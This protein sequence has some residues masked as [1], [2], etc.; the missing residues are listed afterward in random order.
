MVSI[1]LPQAATELISTAFYVWTVTFAYYNESTVV[2][3]ALAAGL[4]ATAISYATNGAAFNPIITYARLLARKVRAT[5][6]AVDVVAQFMG[7]FLASLVLMAG[8]GSGKLGSIAVLPGTRTT[9]ALVS[10]IMASFCMTYLVIKTPEPE[11]VPIVSG[12]ALSGLHMVLL[13]ISGASL[14]P[15]RALAPAIVSGTWG[16]GMWA[17]VVGP[18]VGAAVA[19][20]AERMTVMYET[21][22]TERHDQDGPQVELGE[23]TYDIESRTASMP[24]S[25]DMEGAMARFRAAEDVYERDAAQGASI[26]LRVQDWPGG[27]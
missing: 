25:S 20:F 17:L 7:A 16:R 23:R 6:A 27:A 21:I 4:T 24:V 12:M 18:I 5:Q 10:E 2:T 13:P 14:N 26:S 22:E 8:A 15:V 11:L 1:N 9:E 3:T 19:A